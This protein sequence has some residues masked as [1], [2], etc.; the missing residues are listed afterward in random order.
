MK[1]AQQMLEVGDLWNYFLG[2]LKSHHAEVGRV[3]DRT[4]CKRE[5]ADLE[6]GRMIKLQPLNSEDKEGPARVVEMC[7]STTMYSSIANRLVATRA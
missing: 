3:A 5:K 7:V 1:A 4:G 2:A 6:I